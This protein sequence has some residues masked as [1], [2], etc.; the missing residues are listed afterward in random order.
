MDLWLPATSTT[1]DMMVMA[2]CCQSHA[3]AFDQAVSCKAAKY[4]PAVDNSSIT[5]VVLFIM[6][7]FGILSRPAKAFLKCP[8]GNTTVAKQAKAHLRLAMATVQGT[9]HLSYAWGACAALIVGSN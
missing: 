7:P 6:L 3:K 1:V 4:S 2:A 8:M 5:K 9:A